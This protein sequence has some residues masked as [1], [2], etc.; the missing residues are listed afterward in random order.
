LQRK[1]STSSVITAIV[2][3]YFLQIK[4]NKTMKIKNFI[5]SAC[6]I[7]SF[8]ACNSSTT[9]ITTEEEKKEDT[10]EKA[11]TPEQKIAAADA[12]MKKIEAE[13]GSLRKEKKTYRN[14][15][16]EKYYDVFGFTAYYKDKELV[17][18]IEGMGDEGYISETAYYF[19]GGKVFME[20]YNSSFMGDPYV[21]TR[22]YIEND[23]V[24]AGIGKEKDPQDENT[25]LASLKEAAFTEKT[26]PKAGELK[27][28]LAVTMERFSEAE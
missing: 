7:L 23:E 10:A 6:C 28:Q 15:D 12:D 17:K 13:L 22:T 11:A 24:F 25:K 1:Y 20:T 14:P 9:T 27:K 5:L 8:A 18:L 21:E 3:F 19:K 16:P 2:L 26:M 4:N